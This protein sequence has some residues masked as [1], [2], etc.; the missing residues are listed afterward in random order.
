MQSNIFY[1]CE[2]E[3]INLWL[4]NRWLDAC[5]LYMSKWRVLIG[6]EAISNCMEP[7]GTYDLKI[8]FQNNCLVVVMMTHIPMTICILIQWRKKGRTS[9]YPEPLTFWSVLSSEL[10]NRPL[11][12]IIIGIM[13]IIHSFQLYDLYTFCSSKSTAD[14]SFFRVHRFIAS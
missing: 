9:G 14:N 1:G 8:S 13:L 12:I 10:Y 5:W 3:K 2:W 11:P 7:F 6:L 4:I